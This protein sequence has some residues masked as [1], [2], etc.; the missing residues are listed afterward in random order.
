MKQIRLAGTW[1]ANLSKSQRDPN[2]QFQSLTLHFEISKEAVLL[3]FTGVDKAGKQ[4]SSARTLHPDGQEYPV[5]DASGVV[6]IARWV[7]TDT[8]ETMFKHEGNVI[9]EG[10]YEVSSD[11]KT[12]TSKGKGLDASGAQYEQVIV[13]DR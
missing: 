5:A 7:G 1:T 8:L 13:F 12:L 4:V 9:S 11:G 3:N 2:H 6:E 10:T